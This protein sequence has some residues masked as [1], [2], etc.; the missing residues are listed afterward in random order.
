MSDDGPTD[1]SVV[2]TTFKG[3]APNGAPCLLEILVMDS[4]FAMRQLLLH[5]L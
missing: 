1:V 3:L 4:V 5:V 2:A